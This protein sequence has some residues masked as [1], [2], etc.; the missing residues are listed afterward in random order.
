MC[1]EAAELS[2]HAISTRKVEAMHCRA[3][4]SPGMGLNVTD[5]TGRAS[6]GS[7][8]QLRV[9]GV[10]PEEVVMADGRSWKLHHDGGVTVIEGPADAAA[11]HGLLMRL[12][13]ASAVLLD[14]RLVYCAQ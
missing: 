6:R 8:Y 9:A 2:A 4:H 1:R 14:L 13:H 5:I 11:L 10:V 3:G 7:D 12:R